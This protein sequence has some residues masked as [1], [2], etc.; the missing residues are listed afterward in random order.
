M[1]H[2][3][4]DGI[5]LGRHSD[6]V[7]NSENAARLADAGIVAAVNVSRKQ[8]G[9]NLDPHRFDGHSW[10]T[11]VHVPLRDGSNPQHLFDYAT[12]LLYREA[13]RLWDEDGAVAVYCTMAQSRSPAVL[14]AALA[15]L[16]RQFGKPIY[17]HG[18]TEE[19]Q[20]A[21]NDGR[22]A[23]YEVREALG[24]IQETKHTVQPP[25]ELIDLAI[26]HVDRV[27]RDG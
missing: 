15:R 11:Y 22:I 14:A 23:A 5:Y 21:I 18:S 12:E 8:P 27:M 9:R 17:G 3:V 26:E 20:A 1:L 4:H 7:N 13:V 16:Q 2:Q 10:E 25:Q 19:Y 6:F 24:Y